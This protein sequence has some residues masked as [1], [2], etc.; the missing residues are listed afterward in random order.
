MEDWRKIVS[1]VCEETQVLS[2]NIHSDEHFDFLIRVKSSSLIG[3]D[4]S[5]KCDNWKLRFSTLTNTSWIVGDTFPHPTRFLYGKTFLCQ[6][7]SKHKS[8][9]NQN[10]RQRNQNCNRALLKFRVKKKTYATLT[11]DS[12]LVKGYDVEIEVYQNFLV[13]LIF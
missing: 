4:L 11:S 1:S 7:A 6:H 13:N 10:S 12:L 8:K 9:D 5:S 3:E 2:F